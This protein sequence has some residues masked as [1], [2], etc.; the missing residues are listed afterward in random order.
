MT[1]TPRISHFRKPVQIAV[2][3]GGIAVLADDG[4]IWAVTDN[5]WYKL[6]DI[7]QRPDEGEEIPNE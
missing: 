7:P 4:T 3:P 2:T 1:E 5:K 6:S